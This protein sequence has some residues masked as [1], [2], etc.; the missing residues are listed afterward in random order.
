MNDLSTLVEEYLSTRRALGA[1]LEKS[2]SL[3]RGFVVFAAR[4]DA[5]LL[6]VELALSWATEPRHTDPARWA[7]RLAVLRGFARF[8]SAADPRHQV[9]PTDLLPQRYR[10][11]RPHIYSDMEVASLIGAARKMPVRHELQSLTF[12]T[13][14]G[15]LVV[16]GMRCGE[17]LRLRRDDVDL[18]EGIVAVRAG[19]FGKSRLLPVHDS[20]RQ[21]LTRYATRRDR[22]CPDPTDSTFFL[23]ARGLSVTQGA[24]RRLFLKICQRDGLGGSEQSR[25]P[26]L[27]DLRHTFAVKTLLRWHRLDVDVDAR[28]PRLATYL[29]HVDV[30]STYWYLSATPELLGVAATRLDRTSAE[31]PS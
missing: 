6:T 30:R 4:R 2:A 1:R 20:T 29:G 10:R 18:D 5:A 3:L 23:S 11:P 9:P 17:P 21:A 15:L 13:L 8:A 28:L 7:G 26:R 16:T 31:A 27:H 24:L 19:K 25:N 14:L 22:L 12:A